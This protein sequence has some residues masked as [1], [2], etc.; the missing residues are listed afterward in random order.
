MGYKG[1]SKPTQPRSPQA[2]LYTL[3]CDGL[4]IKESQAR[5]VWAGSPTR[6][7][8]GQLRQ[9]SADNLDYVAYHSSERAQK[10]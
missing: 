7:T 4:A 3:I 9:L 6:F 10:A 5:S 8:L 1:R 2:P